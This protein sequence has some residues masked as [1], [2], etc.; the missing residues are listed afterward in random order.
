[1]E[2]GWDALQGDNTPEGIQ[3]LVK[4][5]ASPEVVGAGEERIR[6]DV[7]SFIMQAASASQLSRLR[8]LEEA[9]VS[10]GSLS[11]GLT[12]SS[13]QRLDFSSEPLISFTLINDGE[14]GLY[15][16]VN[17]HGSNPHRVALTQ[18]EDWVY[19]AGYATINDITVEPAT[20]SATFRLRARTGRRIDGVTPTAKFMD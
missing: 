10:I 19:N 13:R 8:K 20:G 16:E 5:F 2:Q 3:E 1:M 15:A 17:R 14:N 6:P 9:K 4:A 11:I 18:D 12:I 7:M